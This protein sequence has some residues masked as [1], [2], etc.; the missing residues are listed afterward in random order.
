M[1]PKYD[2]V[3]CVEE[4]FALGTMA[5]IGFSI[6]IN[7]SPLNRSQPETLFPQNLDSLVSVHCKAQFPQPTEAAKPMPA[8]ARNA[9]SHSAQQPAPPDE[10]PTSFQARSHPTESSLELDFGTSG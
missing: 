7:H 5:K 1:Y 8:R 10:I 2:A 9:Q 4:T 3:K 6:L